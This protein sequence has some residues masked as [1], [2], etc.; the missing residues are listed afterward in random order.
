MDLIYSFYETIKTETIKELGFKMRKGEK[1]AI[2][3]DEWTSQ[4]NR[5]YLNITLHDIE[6]DYNLGLA[7]IATSCDG[8]TMLKLVTS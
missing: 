4:A 5:R 3:V 6:K 1:F 2:T 8:N 7:S